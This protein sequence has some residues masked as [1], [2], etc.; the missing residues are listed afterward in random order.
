MLEF[1]VRWSY[2][3]TTGYEEGVTRMSAESHE[4]AES[5]FY[6]N[7]HPHRVNGS[8]L[9]WSVDSVDYAEVGYD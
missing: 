6:E 7:N 8:Y 9:G 5:K 2:Q 3:S 1:L 4:D